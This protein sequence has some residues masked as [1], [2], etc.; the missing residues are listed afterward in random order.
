MPAG[1]IFR[2]VLLRCRVLAKKE[3]ANEAKV[4]G[5]VGHVE[6]FNPA[7]IAVKPY[8]SNPM[9]I[10]THRLAQFNPRGTD[11]PDLAEGR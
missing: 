11:V 2:L 9:F 8:L 5:M 10:E 3:L 4:K 7:Y 6:R 1:K